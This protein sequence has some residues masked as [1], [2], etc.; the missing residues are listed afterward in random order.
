M[1]QAVLLAEARDVHKGG[2][3]ALRRA[4]KIP[5]ILYGQGQEVLGL[6]L[7]AKSFTQTITKRGEKV[8]F[9]LQMGGQK[10]DALLRE[11][12]TDPV[13]DNFVHLDFYRVD[14]NKEIETEVPL[15]FVGTAAGI[16]LGGVVDIQLRVVRV[17][18]MPINLPERVEV[19]ITPLGIGHALHVSDLKFPEGVAAAMDGGRAVVTV[20]APMKEEEVKPAAGAEGEAAAAGAEGAAPAEGAAAADGAAPAK[21]GAAA[22]PAKDAKAAPAKDAKKK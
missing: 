14:M 21:D 18:C 3:N 4:G 6:T 8:I 5:A 16:I 10:Y 1:E 13:T 15:A 9:A 7:D 22:A 17:R 2:T 12:Q 19:D 20:T 11:V